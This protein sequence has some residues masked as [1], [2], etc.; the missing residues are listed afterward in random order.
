MK[1]EVWS[2]T[3]CPWCD[4]AKTILTQLNIPYVEFIISAGFDENT[5]KPNQRYVT[6]AELL[7]KLPTAKTVPQIWIDDKHIGG[8]TD[9][10]EAIRSGEIKAA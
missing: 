4:R 10:E 7:E 1:A 3:T 9:L 8:C 6:K 5:P 2:K